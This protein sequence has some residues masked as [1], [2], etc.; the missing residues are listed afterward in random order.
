MPASSRCS[1]TS[2]T[3]PDPHNWCRHEA[4]AI[5]PPVLNFNAIRIAELKNIRFNQCT[6]DIQHIFPHFSFQYSKASS[7]PISMHINVNQTDRLNNSSQK[8]CIIEQKWLGCR[9][10]Y[11]ND[12]YMNRM[13]CSSTIATSGCVAVPQ[14]PLQDVLQFL[15]CHFRMCCSSSIVTSG[16]VVV[17]QLPL[18]DVL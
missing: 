10:H 17:P 14:L 12:S 11:K 3:E 16:C 8:S 7:S 2:I 1:R 9:V 6:I 4:D 13:C 5:G 15:N 18:Q